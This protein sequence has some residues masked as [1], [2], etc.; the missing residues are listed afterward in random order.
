MSEF[1]F[2]Q[3]PD[4]PNFNL[5]IPYAMKTIDR[6]DP[7]FQSVTHCQCNEKYFRR[8]ELP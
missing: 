6:Q 2:A 4:K 1:Q 3:T 5:A 7:R 8:E